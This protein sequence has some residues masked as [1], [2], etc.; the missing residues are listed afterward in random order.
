MLLKGVYDCALGVRLHGNQ[1]HVDLFGELPE[2]CVDLIEGRRAIDLRFAAAEKIEIGAVDH[3]HSQPRSLLDA[4]LDT[5][6]AVPEA[7]AAMASATRMPLPRHLTRI[8]RSLLS[9]LSGTIVRDRS[10]CPAGG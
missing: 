3:Q 1:I 2:A 6:S 8:G 5:A 4:W 9:L 10:P 7:L